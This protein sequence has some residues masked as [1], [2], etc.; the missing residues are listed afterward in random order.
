MDDFEQDTIVGNTASDKQDNA[1]V[2]EGTG[3]QEFTV[4]NPGSNLK[5][6]ENVVNVQTLER[7]FSERND[8]EICNF[9]D[10]VEVRNQNAYLT[11]NDSII[12]PEN[13]L[14]IR[15]INASSRRDATSVTANSKVGDHVRSF[16]LFWKRIR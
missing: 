6:N 11:A 14:A 9:V 2:N 1:T 10:T 13:E 4:G 8:R 12:A 3:D 5:A 15:L 16:N 7:C